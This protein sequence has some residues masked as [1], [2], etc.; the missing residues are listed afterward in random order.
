MSRYAYPTARLVA[1]MFW[2][3]LLTPC[4]AYAVESRSD[5]AYALLKTYCADCHGRA[6]SQAG[7]VLEGAAARK[8]VERPERRR[9]MLTQLLSHTMPPAGAT[10]LPASNRTQLVEWLQTLS[11][12]AECGPP[13]NAGKVVMRRL[14]RNEYRHTV[15]DL[16]GVDYTP[17]GDFPGDDVGYGFDNIGDVLSLPPSLMEKYLAAAEAITEEAIWTPAPPESWELQ[18]SP[19]DFENA[20]SFS[21]GS[22]LAMY[23]NGT[24]AWTIDAPFDGTYTLTLTG[25]GD[26]AGR[27]PVEVE[28]LVDGNRH[29]LKIKE[30]EPTDKVIRQK[31]SRGR[32]RFEISFTNDH[33][34]SSGADRNLYLHHAL[35]SGVSTTDADSQPDPL[36]ESH[37]QLLF[38]QPGDGVDTQ[39]ATQE[40][41]ARFASRAYRRPITRGELNRLADLAAD[42][43]QRGGSFERGVQV[44]MQAVMVSPYFLFRVERPR[45]VDPEGPMPRINDYELAT[46][47]SY[48]LCNSTPDLT[49]LGLAHRGRLSDPEV[50]TEQVR[51]LLA[52]PRSNRFIEDF[53]S[54]W[55]QLRQLEKVQPDRDVFPE[56]DDSL[57]RAM[58]WET[59]RFVGDLIRNNRPMDQLLSA[60]FS[61]LNERLA[62]FYGVEGIHGNRFERVQMKA[63][64]HGGL[65]S[66]AS[67]LTVTSN[68]TR[69]SPVKRGK[70][71][72]DNL[73]N[74]PPPPA[75]P[76]VPSL[77]ESTVTAQSVR[78]QMELHR[79]H[80]TCS[81]CHQ[82]MDPLGLTLEQFDPIGRW[83]DQQEGL[84]ID[85]STELPDGTALNGVADL[86]HLLAGHRRETFLRGVAEK[87][88]IYALGRGLEPYDRC[89]VDEILARTHEAGDRFHALILAIVQSDP[90]QKQGF[91]PSS[92]LSEE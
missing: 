28:I 86:R 15:L 1:W 52:D 47:L 65:L 92:D 48:F 84:P 91:R 77:E 54:Q 82:T 78:E 32:H 90:F 42:V 10:P 38:R 27:E 6:D 81:A 5:N 19:T 87:F 43:R 83:R 57:R 64:R 29:I 39:Q 21:V 2:A 22:N 9:R 16:T 34:V 51:R 59:I 7:L 18:V 36:P 26:Q 88:L 76:G 14:N 24:V 79:R 23:F 61:Y 66:H 70:W 71:I 30:T 4:S 56:F 35:L 12:E 55:L 50:L 40:V 44:A 69:T 17:A 25:S 3:T 13:G 41:L 58:Y 49:L 45:R 85:A 68:P 37:R 60:D 31:L 74:T 20:E 80:P 46:R 73:L 62:S 72:L 8:F 33:F 63:P 75:P 89:A 67:V 11:P 53:T